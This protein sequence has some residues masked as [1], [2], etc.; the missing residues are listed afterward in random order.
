[1]SVLDPLPQSPNEASFRQELLIYATLDAGKSWSRPVIAE[2]SASSGLNRP[3]LVAIPASSGHTATWRLVFAPGASS[4]ECFSQTHCVGVGG[5]VFLVSNN[6]GSGWRSEKLPTGF[7]P[8]GLACSG[9]LSCVLFGQLEATDAATIVTT[10]DGGVSWR[11][12]PYPVL[13]VNERPP[14]AVIG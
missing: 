1:M 12:S 11:S 3:T 7:S 13:P 4:V 6:G 14:A 2:R 10:S 5:A 8:S 9:P